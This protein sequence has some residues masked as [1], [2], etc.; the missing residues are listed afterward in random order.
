MNFKSLILFLFLASLLGR[1]QAISIFPNSATVS[2]KP[3][4]V[5]ALQLKVYGHPT[6][7][8]IE[9]VKSMDIKSLDDKTLTVFELGAEQQ[10]TVPI[11]IVIPN[12]SIEYYLCAVLR[13]SQ[14][15]RLR[16]CTAVRVIVKP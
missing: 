2:G 9:L 8:S 14:S 16:V 12:E 15:M 11:D 13:S 7:A 10:Y 1:A 6:S 5:A 3:G 4:S